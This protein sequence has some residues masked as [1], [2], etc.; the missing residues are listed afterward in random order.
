MFLCVFFFPF[1]LYN[2]STQ[3][4]NSKP[5]VTMYIFNNS[6][7]GNCH[8]LVCNRSLSDKL[9]R[10]M[11]CFSCV[12]QN[13]EMLKMY[14]INLY[15]NKTIHITESLLNVS[16]YNRKCENIILF[17]HSRKPQKNIVY[18]YFTDLKCN[19]REW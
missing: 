11:V 17:N 4:V 14:F 8:V 19:F 12:P 16:F 5:K 6:F 1:F 9:S 2:T 13:L 7:L 3:S 15:I 18:I 10:Y